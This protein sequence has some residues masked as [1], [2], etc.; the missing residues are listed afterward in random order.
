MFVVCSGKVDSDSVV[1][2]ATRDT[3]ERLGHMFHLDGKK[4]NPSLHRFGWDVI[5]VAKLK[6]THTGDTLC[7][8]K[9][10]VV[11]RPLVEFAPVHFFC[12]WPEVAG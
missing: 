11:F 4:Q 12:P 7:D 6:D 10:P 5:A 2:N 9:A 8:E 3:K 1:L